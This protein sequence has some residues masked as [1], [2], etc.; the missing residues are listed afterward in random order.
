MLQLLEVV[1]VVPIMERQ[2]H[3]P[4]NNNGN[5]GHSEMAHDSSAKSPNGVIDQLMVPETTTNKEEPMEE[6]DRCSPYF[7]EW[8]RK[9][10]RKTISNKIR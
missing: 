5:G 1:P 2:T 7:D 4:L 9:P 6:S 3:P 10:H 8:Y